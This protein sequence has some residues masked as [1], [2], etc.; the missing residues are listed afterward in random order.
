MTVIILYYYNEAVIYEH[1]F[2][3][4]KFPVFK[5]N[6]KSVRR[7]QLVAFMILFGRSRIQSAYENGL[8]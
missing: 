5:H 3:L 7:A 8:S 2:S 1:P 6:A 4:S